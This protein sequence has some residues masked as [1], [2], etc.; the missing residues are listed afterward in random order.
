MATREQKQWQHHAEEKLLR[1]ARKQIKR[2]REA[3]QARRSE[4][5]WDGAVDPADDE[6]PSFERVMPRGERER[7]RAN[8]QT[9]LTEMREETEETSAST[10]ADGPRGIVVEVSSGL[11]RVAV[12]GRTVICSVRGSLTAAETGFTNVVAVGD[13]V[14]ISEDEASRGVVE[15]VLPR[16]NYLARPDVFLSHLQQVIVAN[17]D[18]LL[19]VA[20]WREPTIWLELIDRYLITA[21]RSRLRPLICVNKIDLA[22]TLAACRAEL[23]PYH[24]LGYPVIFTSAQTGEGIEE[25]RK[26]LRGQTT[27]LA[28]LSGVGKSSLLAAVQPGLNLRTSAVS[29]FSG[30]GRHT[31]TQVTMLELEMGGFVVDT[32]GIREFGLNGLRRSE[33]ASFYPEIAAAARRCRFGDCSHLRE[34]GCAVIAAVQQGKLSAARYRSYRKIYLDLPA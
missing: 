30:Q 26:V 28:G 12:D 19:I 22:E 2:H 6:S 31:T 27:A 8:L 32:P 23:K 1:K 24:D 18:Q 14:I 21:A 20:S 34:P 9:A 15:T 7:R 16:R 13:A 4:W 25:L 33:L 11:C 3:D 17:I 29:D 10:E 5:R